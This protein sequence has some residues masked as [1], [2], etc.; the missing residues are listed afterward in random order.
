M[1]LL[2]LILTRVPQ[3]GGSAGDSSDPL[4]R[5]IAVV[6]VLFILSVITEK[7]TQ[8]VRTYP[9]Q[10]RAIGIIFCGVC[11]V[12]LGMTSHELFVDKSYSISGG[13]I[14]LLFVLTTILLIWILA[15][16]DFVQPSRTPK[17]VRKL[18]ILQNVANDAVANDRVKEKEVTVLSFLIGFA[19]A[20]SFKADLI[21]LF[22][23][24]I[25]LGWGHITFFKSGKFL[26]IDPEYFGIDPTLMLGFL[27]TAFFL[28]FG[29][30]FFHDLLDNL[31]QVKNLKRKAIEKETYEATSIKEFDDQLAKTTY[32]KN[33]AAIAG[34]DGVTGVSFG[35]LRKDGSDRFGLRVFTSKP[36]LVLKSDL[37]RDIN[38]KPV[39]I[40]IDADE[41]AEAV[42]ASAQV[43]NTK[44]GAE[45]GTICIGVRD[46][47]SPG[48][49]YFLTCYHVVKDA[50]HAWNEFK[51]D[52]NSNDGVIIDKTTKGNIVRGIRTQEMDAALIKLNAGGIVNNNIPL[53]NIPITSSRPTFYFDDDATSVNVYGATTKEKRSGLIT[54]LG[55]RWK[56]N[57]RD[58]ST[59]YEMV[60]LIEIQKDGRTIVKGGDSGALIFTDEGEA[61]GM[62]VATTKK[63]TLAIPIHTILTHWNLEIIT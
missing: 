53:F 46:V 32:E 26:V 10:F 57:F 56:I 41:S 17:A 9:K 51:P 19:V 35:R 14:F 37:I 29:S 50:G 31:L 23:G 62:V 20:Y 22:N 49:V 43:M 36:E 24:K 63:R 6:I 61:L 58:G 34:L 39:P 11:Y 38:G 30:K 3:D 16:M 28:A 8:L 13:A 44:Q 33:A 27:L 15:N 60:N 12:T 2:N 7:F 4:D 48:D 52:A 47:G 40:Y 42:S 18:Q 5:L 25:A 59:G 45:K 54:G 55:A 21:T 1:S